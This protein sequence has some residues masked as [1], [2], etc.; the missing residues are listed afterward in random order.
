MEQTVMTHPQNLTRLHDGEESLRS[1]SIEAIEAF[2]DLL[3]HARLVESSMDLIDY[4]A[5][6][7][8]HA[9]EDQLTIQCLGIRLFN[10]TASALKLLLSGY[11]QSSAFQQRDLLETIF[12]L[13]YLRSNRSEI[14]VWR[15]GDAKTHRDRFRPAKIRKALDDRDGFTERKRSKAYQLLCEL[16]SHPTP[17]GF[18]M[19]T[20]VA[21]GNAHCGP[22]FEH[23]AMSAVLSELAKHLVQAAE[24]FHLFFD[25]RNR[26]DCETKVSFLEARGLWLE[27]FFGHPFDRRKVE[28]LRAHLSKVH[29]QPA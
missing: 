11:Y 3:A 24:V 6:Q 2:P 14:P 1:K 22:F 10:G 27:K 19:L 29:A 18:R 23:T 7:Y 4:F 9:D 12:L 13:D 26:A 21:G 8:P 20:P 5:R 17:T 16:A 28:E 15:A 25:P